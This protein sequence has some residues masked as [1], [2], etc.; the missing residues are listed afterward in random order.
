[1]K[2]RPLAFA[3]LLAL[4][5]ASVAATAPAATAAACGDQVIA[6]GGFESGS[7]GWTATSGVVSTATAQQPAHGGTQMGWL[8]GYGSAH[9]DTVSQSVTLP[10]GC[11]SASLTYWLHIDSDETTTTTKFDTL[12]AQIGSTTVASY[13]NLDKATGYQQR[14][15]D[16]TPFL[17]QTVTLKFTG[18]EDASLSTDFVVDDIALT[19]TGGS[20]NQSPTVTN[21][22]PQSGTVGQAASLQIQA[23]DPQGDSLTYSATG[24][25]AGLSINATTGL[26]SGTPSAAG[27]SSA[28][29]TARDPGGHT[30]SATFSWTVTSGGSDGTRTPSSP[31]YTVNLSSNSTGDTW[32]GTESVSF[33]NASSTPLPEVYLRLWDNFHGSCPQTPITVTNVTGGTA[34]PLSVNCTAM[35]ITLPTPLN[36]GQSA[37]IGFNLGIVVPSGAD[38]FGHDGP[39]N[40][41]GNALPV[42]AI[43]D[44]AGW[45]LDPYTN[46][47]ESFYTVISNFDVT[48][49]H[50]TALPTPASGKSTETTSGGTTTTHAI[51]NNVRDFAWATGPFTKITGTSS[52]G[53]VVNVYSTSGI[54]SGNAQSMLST[55]TNALDVHSGRFGDYPYGEADVVL[56]NNFWFGGM[57]YPGF[58]LDV[59]SSTALAHELAHQWFYGIVGDDEYSTPW[60]DEGFTDYATDLYNGI[61]GA[62]CGITWQS[63]AE[64]LTNNMG[65]WDAHSSRYSTVIYGY[66]KCTLHDLR[67]LLGDTTM[68]NLLKSYAQSHWYGVSTVAEFKAAAQAA[69]GSTDLTSFWANHRVEG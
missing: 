26:I 60:L 27:S 20:G 13:S 28:T 66:G 57:E 30:G 40:F 34:S 69:A 19:T 45:H 67:R 21:P 56:D 64:K 63:S 33:T 36:Q 22:G 41:I 42:L 29:V 58:V 14:T 32:T 23:S 44:T 18:V 8:D 54:S 46:N 49:A 35:K 12:V 61:T 48:L 16:A 2:R 1:M 51:A 47:G 37:T 55:A 24:L 5:L 53:F 43:R 17:G 52:K 39:N 11:T 10:A 4:G 6:N 62:G 59:V 50:P 9:T 15:I 31:S 25:P 68:A 38:R 3:I 65:Y 7:S